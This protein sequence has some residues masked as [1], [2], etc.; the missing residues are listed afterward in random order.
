[1]DQFLINKYGLDNHLIY[2]I[3]LFLIYKKE[4][5]NVIKE[6]DKFSCYNSDY[7]NTLSRINRKNN[8]YCKSTIWWPSVHSMSY[9]VLEE[10]KD[11]EL[12]DNTIP[13]ML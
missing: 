9:I 7:T 5:D 8:T 1:M 6:M 4:Y 2:H 3:S 11:K 12:I 13:D 10:L